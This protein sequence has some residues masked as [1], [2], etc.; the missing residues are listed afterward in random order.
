[1]LR[2]T[3]RPER[4]Q[5]QARHPDFFKRNPRLFVDDVDHPYTT[6]EALPFHWIRSRQVGGRTLTWGGVTLRMSPFEL[7]AQSWPIRY[8][9]LAPYYDRVERFLGVRGARDGL[10]Q[11][12]DGTF[13]APCAMTPGERAL[14]ALVEARLPDRRV[15]H[16]R[17]ISARPEGEAPDA[18]PAHTSQGGALAAALRTQRTT[19]VPDAVVYE[20]SISPDSGKARGV[21]AID[22]NSRA[23][24]ELRAGFV[25]LAAS[26]LETTRILLCSRSPRH[27]ALGNSSGVLGRFLMDHPCTSVLAAI[28]GLPALASPPP[29]MGPEGILVPH[30]APTGGASAGAFGIFGGVQRRVY[31]SKVFARGDARI[32]LTAYGEMS[33]RRENGVTLDP[34]AVDTF[35]VPALHIRC[36]LTDRERALVAE[37]DQTLAQILD[38][39]G[40]HTRPFASSLPV[41]GS[42]VHEVGTARMGLDPR[43]SVVDSNNRCWD[44]DN[45]LVVD[46]ACWVSS[47]WQNPTLTMMA[48]A[49]RACARLVASLRS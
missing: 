1:M 18:W 23:T 33:A 6:P 38:A 20:V 32:Q 11:L 13:R 47:G 17:G 12:P 16:S 27:P 35:G 43:D 21:S 26:T 42:T 44:A 10:P 15:I 30:S 2:A 49:V 39:A 19:L 40:A 34:N 25:V 3:M 48:I 45:V 4:Q 28:P 5:I 14:K 29:L 8:D 36:A 37:M 46:G 31:N 7:D 41:P 24:Y 22:A 9:D